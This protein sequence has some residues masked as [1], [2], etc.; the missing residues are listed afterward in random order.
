MAA[1]KRISLTLLSEYLTAGPSRRKSIIAD[2][3]T[4]PPFIVRTYNAASNAIT[5]DIVGGD[6]TAVS[7][8]IAKLN[9]ELAGSMPDWQKQ[10]VRS[11]VEAL[12]KFLAQKKSLKLSQWTIAPPD[13]G[14]GNMLIAG[15][16]LA[17]SP[18]ALLIRKAGNEVQVG[19]LKFYFTKTKTLSKRRADYIGAIMHWYSEKHLAA[20]GVADYRC[21]LVANIPGNEIALLY[22][23]NHTQPI[24]WPH[25]IE[26]FHGCSQQAVFP[27]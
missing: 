2:A 19:A 24:E 3:A 15:I 18:E 20:L 1:T 11:C 10:H 12:E 6:G 22:L 21:S 4:P 13:A 9:A 8:A 23:T 7:T 27:R 26:V 5:A 16:R 14:P 25:Q 17:V